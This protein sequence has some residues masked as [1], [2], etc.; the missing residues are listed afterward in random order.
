MYQKVTFKGWDSSPVTQV[1]LAHS[2]NTTQTW[3][4]R[5]KHKSTLDSQRMLSDHLP[6]PPPLKEN[7]IL[8][9]RKWVAVHDCFLSNMY[10]SCALNPPSLLLIS[11]TSPCVISLIGLLLT[12]SLS[13]NICC[14]EQGSTSHFQGW[15]WWLLD[16]CEAVLGE[17]ATSLGGHQPAPLG[18]LWDVLLFA[19]PGVKMS[20]FV[21]VYI[22]LCSAIALHALYR[23]IMNTFQFFN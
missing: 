20:I 23:E 17:R 5:G 9:K 2:G 16:H 22:C 10:I 6:L 21:F 4:M 1:A 12:H 3:G 14:V 18:C 15:G 11:P 13:P 7:E 19:V 8:C